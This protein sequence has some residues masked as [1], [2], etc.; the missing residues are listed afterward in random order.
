MQVGWDTYFER[1]G[2]QGLRLVVS[3]LLEEA[4]FET[5]R[6]E[7]PPPTPDEDRAQWIA[8]LAAE[9]AAVA[10]RLLERLDARAAARAPRPERWAEA[11]LH[12][13]M[14]GILRAPGPQA[15]A[16]LHHLARARPAPLPAAEIRAAAELVAPEV[17]QQDPGSRP[18]WVAKVA[19]ARGEVRELEQE[20]RELETRVRQLETRLEKAL[21][22]S[23]ALEQR[24]SHR[25]EEIKTLRAE[26]KSTRDERGRLEREAVRLRR[27]V[28]EL[29]E[30][31]ARERTGEITTALRRLTTEQ[32]RA[33]AT[34]DKLRA[35][36]G[37][38]REILREQGR[39]IEQLAGL[40]E[41]VASVEEAQ[42]R[43]AARAQEEILRELGAIRG[44]LEGD[45][46]P[47][48]RVEP[49]RP[50][51]PEGKPRIGLF[52]DVQNMFYGAREKRAR[53]DFEALLA[54]VTSGRRLVRAVAY[55]VETPEI[56]QSSFI[57]LLQMKA[58]EVKRK[59]LK[60]R[61]DRSMKG[62]WDLEMALDALTTAEHLDVVVLATG[63]GDFVPL[64]QQLKLRGLRV[65]V[66][67][68]RP[69]TAPDLREAADRFVA[70]TR[71]LLRPLPAPRR[72]T[73]RE[74]T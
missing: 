60:I 40:L 48:P 32:R 14:A 1:L 57:H 41:R 16:V 6:G 26:L 64:V 27:R 69:S 36:E 23:A 18:K 33:G 21:E 24:L 46:L 74:G 28:D 71:R 37:G 72:R 51:Q 65:E 8:D 62:N 13:T 35:G 15:A 42:A 22:R 5:L 70:I 45:P 25:L 52:V 20:R 61:P 50:T 63:D 19:T 29:L 54:S 44:R 4:D 49:A 59:P 12:E 66:Y 53:L 68:F 58:Y 56:D 11:E 38:R 10:R 34:L 2:P 39:R 47:A 17:L 73:A 67:G 9:D 30:R 7:A 55:V 31:R 43:V 3:T